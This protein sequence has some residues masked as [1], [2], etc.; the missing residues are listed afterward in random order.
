MSTDHRGIYIHGTDSSFI[1]L[2]PARLM[3]LKGKFR[4]I[5]LSLIS[6]NIEHRHSLGNEHSATLGN[7][8]RDILGIDTLGIEH[9]DTLGIEHRDTLGLHSL[10]TPVSFMVSSLRSFQIG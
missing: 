8:H 2:R 1:K 7:E 4:S 10:V 3:P 9:R 6:P 5:H